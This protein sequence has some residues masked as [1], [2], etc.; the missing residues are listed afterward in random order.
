MRKGHSDF[1]SAAISLEIQF[2]LIGFSI[3][4]FKVDIV[5]AIKIYIYFRSCYD[6]HYHKVSIKNPLIIYSEELGFYET[7]LNDFSGPQLLQ[8]IN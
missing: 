3:L 4:V 7:Q 1:R 8:A 6:A 5:S 2:L